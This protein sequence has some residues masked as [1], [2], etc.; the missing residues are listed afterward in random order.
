FKLNRRR[1]RGGMSIWS[2]PH[3]NGGM[4]LDHLGGAGEQRR[5]EGESERFCRLEVDKELELS[6]L[7]N[8]DVARFGPFQDLV[9]VIGHAPEQLRQI[10][11]VTHQR[12]GLHVIAVGTDGRQ[13]CLH[14][15]LGDQHAVR[16]KVSFTADQH[17]V[18]PLLLHLS[19]DALNLR[20]GPLLREH[21]SQRNSESVAGV[22]ASRVIPVRLPPGRPRLVTSPACSGSSMNATTGIVLVAALKAITTGLVPVTITSGLRVT[23][24]RTK[25]E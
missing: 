4:S 15:K 16:V 9:H 17:C 8:R 5:R 3:D 25:S 2:I 1:A 20:G 14:S 7:I 18:R 21:E 10:H 12:T 24:S 22:P 13:A 11:G 19:E 6:G 23:I